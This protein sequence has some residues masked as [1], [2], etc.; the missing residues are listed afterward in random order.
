MKKVIAKSGR[1]LLNIKAYRVF[2]ILISYYNSER[3]GTLE[4]LNKVA[5]GL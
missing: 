1:K 2:I 5:I 4:S 3:Q